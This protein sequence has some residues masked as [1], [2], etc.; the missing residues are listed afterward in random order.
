MPAFFPPAIT[1]LRGLHVMGGL[2]GGGSSEVMGSLLLICVRL[3]SLLRHTVYLGRKCL[4]G[5]SKKSSKS[6]NV[7]S[8]VIMGPLPQ[9]PSH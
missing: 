8:E 1:L 7:S 4:Q 3:D 5:I 6:N 2:L 9:L